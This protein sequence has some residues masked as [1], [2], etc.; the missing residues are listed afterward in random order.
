MSRLGCY[1]AMAGVGPALES[2]ADLAMAAF[3]VWCSSQGFDFQARALHARQPSF[4]D[5]S[6][7]AASTLALGFAS[8]AWYPM[9]LPLRVRV[10]QSSSSLCPAA[11]L[12]R[13]PRLRCSGVAD[14][15][16]LSKSRRQP[17]AYAGG[18]IAKVAVIAILLANDEA[19]ASSPSYDSTP[20]STF[21][22]P[23]PKFGPMVRSIGRG[24]LLTG[25]AA[26]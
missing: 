4:K 24:T 16:V 13:S 9:F 25:M 14:N 5:H 15:V 2:T 22:R 17:R 12:V 10:A 26:A 8:A 20:P 19:T 1:R 23:W 11:L 6:S 3:L 21:R 7:R 18:G